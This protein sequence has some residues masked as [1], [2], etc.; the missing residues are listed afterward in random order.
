[1]HSCFEIKRIS[2]QLVV[3]LSLCGDE[4]QIEPWLQKKKHV[5]K[6]DLHI[7]HKIQNFNCNN[8][9]VHCKIG[10]PTSQINNSLG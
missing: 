3:V 1:M 4:W 10:P 8:T 2:S 7:D 6:F 5:L 9:A